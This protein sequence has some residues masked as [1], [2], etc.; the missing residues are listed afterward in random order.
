MRS[1]ATI[2]LTREARKKAVDL[3]VNTRIDSSDYLLQSTD[4]SLT[5]PRAMLRNKRTLAFLIL[6]AF[7][8]AAGFTEGGCG[9]DGGLL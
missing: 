3:R 9:T 2:D 4:I 1:V 8:L 5:A 7:H 6:C